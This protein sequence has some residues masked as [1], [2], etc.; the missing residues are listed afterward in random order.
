MSSNI[1][2]LNWKDVFDA[3]SSGQGAKIP[4]IKN[5]VANGN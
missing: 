5:G 3:G 2:I 1:K 4:P